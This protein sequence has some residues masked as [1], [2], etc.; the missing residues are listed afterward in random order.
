MLPKLSIT[1]LPALVSSNWSVHSVVPSV[2]AAEGG[3]KLRGPGQVPQLAQ[4]SVA[5]SAKW[6]AD[7][8]PDEGMRGSPTEDLLS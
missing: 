8:L 1:S 7:S 5:A 6:G 2:P 4:A 3:T